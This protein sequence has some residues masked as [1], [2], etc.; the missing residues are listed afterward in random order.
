[1][2]TTLGLDSCFS[3]F[4]FPFSLFFFMIRIR[5]VI[6]N[7]MVTLLIGLLCELELGRGCM[8]SHLPGFSP[9]LFD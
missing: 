4:G 5:R 2:Q 7:E 8:N 6:F 1:M 3:Y 9:I